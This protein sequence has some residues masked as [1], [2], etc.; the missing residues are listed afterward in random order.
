MTFLL[1]ETGVEIKVYGDDLNYSY[2]TTTGG[3]H[4]AEADHL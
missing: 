1:D 3:R 2:I 4:V